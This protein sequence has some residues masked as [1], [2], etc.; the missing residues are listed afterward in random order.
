MVEL[1]VSCGLTRLR[2]AITGRAVAMTVA[3]MSADLSLFMV[4][5]TFFSMVVNDV[6]A[7]AK[8]TEVI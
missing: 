5:F 6:S 4:F 7:R 3:M 2:W 1:M 8:V